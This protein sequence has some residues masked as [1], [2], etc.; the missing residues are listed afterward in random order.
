MSTL[1]IDIETVGQD[2]D[3]LDATTQD[4]LTWWI[5]KEA[6]DD[7][8]YQGALADLKNNLG[9][10]PL[11]GAIV[12]IGVLDVEQKKGAVYFQAPGQT[13]PPFEEENFKFEALTEAEML[14]KFWQGTAKY[15]AF[16]TFNGKSFDIPFLMIRSAIHQVRPAKNLMSNRYL[17][18]QKF[19]CKHIDLL[20]EL[21]FYGAV[22]KKGNLHLWSR[23][24]TVKSPKAQGI[25]GDDVS[26]LF[27]EKK[28][29]DIA[30]Y[31]TGDLLAT[32]ALYQ[33]WKK[34][35]NFN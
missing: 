4:S 33:Y 21:T 26:R 32:E 8:A 1:I 18:S 29:I 15:D 30:R 9:F 34:Y 20:D 3:A 10:S 5:K 12:V 14:Q 25:T 28:F 23:A 2:F 13:I 31:N 16:V 22:R 24:F 27:A 35:L 11:T 6:S 7:A 19:G 17:S